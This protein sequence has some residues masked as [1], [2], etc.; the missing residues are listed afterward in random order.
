LIKS[1]NGP[2]GGECVGEVKDGKPHGQGATTHA[3][4]DKYV[5][6]FKG[7]REHG[8]GT[9]TYPGGTIEKGTWRNGELVE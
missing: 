2:L 1:P 7:G 8:Q 5:G 3:D 6:E 4:G 9:A